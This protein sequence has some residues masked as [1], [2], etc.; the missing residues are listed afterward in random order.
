MILRVIKKCEKGYFEDDNEVMRM[1]FP[2]FT[3][4]KTSTAPPT[5]SRPPRDDELGTGAG[6]EDLEPNWPCD[7]SGV[8]ALV[9]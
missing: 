7:G 8:G 4:S 3:R 9:A 5:A 1:K 6:R 2:D